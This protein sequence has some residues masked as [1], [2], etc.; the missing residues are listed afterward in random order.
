MCMSWTLAQ[1]TALDLPKAAY[2]VPSKTIFFCRWLR[3]SANYPTY[4]VRLF[5]RDRCRFND[6]RH[7]QRDDTDGEIGTLRE[8]CL[9]FIFF[10]GLYEW[11][12]KHNKYSSQEAREGLLRK[13]IILH[14]RSSC[15]AKHRVKLSRWSLKVNGMVFTVD[16]SSRVLNATCRYCLH[17]QPRGN[18]FSM[19]APIRPFFWQH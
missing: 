17:P 2:Y 10:K 7:G 3:C 14:P 16:N 15:Y 4:Q 9:H 6:F 5:H 1:P 19:S 13:R 12:A 11:F 8:P 18:P